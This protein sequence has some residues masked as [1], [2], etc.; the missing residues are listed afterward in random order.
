MGDEARWGECKAGLG[1]YIGC[2][3]VLRRGEEYTRVV[4][5]EVEGCTATVVGE[6]VEEVPLPSL[7]LCGVGGG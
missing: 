6:E 5:E 1:I 3:A 4:V 2:T 7:V